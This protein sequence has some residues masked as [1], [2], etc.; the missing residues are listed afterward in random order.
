MQ[1]K[2]DPANARHGFAARDLECSRRKMIDLEHMAIRIAMDKV[3]ADE[4]QAAVNRLLADGVYSDHFLAIMD[5]KPARLAEV[6]PPFQ[7]Y[8]KTAGI[9]APDKE[10]AVWRIIAYHVSRI[11]SGQTTPLTEL[12]ALIAEVYWDYD[13]HSVTTKY[14]GDSHGIE[15]LIGLYWEYD[16]ATEG[17]LGRMSDVDMRNWE[18]A[19]LSRSEEWIKRFA[20]K[21]IHAIGVATPQHDG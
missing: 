18:Q 1:M 6:L 7:A 3:D 9:S 21:A 20:N 5:A 15:H 14:L 4:I 12:Q 8:L 2:A 13:F 16:D 10:E 19:V 17:P 11:V